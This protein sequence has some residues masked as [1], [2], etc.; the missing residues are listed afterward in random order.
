M[1]VIGLSPEATS[2][3]YWTRRLNR[4]FHL[5]F[6]FEPPKPLVASLRLKM[7]ET[8]FSEISDLTINLGLSIL[9]LFSISILWVHNKELNKQRALSEFHDLDKDFTHFQE[10]LRAIK[11]KGTLSRKEYIRYLDNHLKQIETE[12]QRRKVV[13]DHHIEK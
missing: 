9:L 11:R 7:F 8:N 10:D 13:D 1:R 2:A 4:F 6:S 5:R 12:I 3:D